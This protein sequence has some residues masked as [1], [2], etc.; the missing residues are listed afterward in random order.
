MRESLEV[1]PPFLGNHG[2]P[3]IVTFGVVNNFFL[4]ATVTSVVAFVWLSIVNWLMMLACSVVLLDT[5]FE[6]AIHSTFDIWCGT[7]PFG[8]KGLGSNQVIPLPELQVAVVW[9]PWSTKACVPWT[10]ATIS[11][12]THYAQPNEFTDYDVACQVGKAYNICPSSS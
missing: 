6:I 9:L 2:F 8:Q 11:L 7:W 5:Q 1:T 4:W 3:V 12:H 10:C